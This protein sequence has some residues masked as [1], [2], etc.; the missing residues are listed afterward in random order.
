MKAKL[1]IEEKVTFHRNVEAEFPDEMSEE[2]IENLLQDADTE[3]GYSV[4][5]YIYYLK[6]HGAK[7]EVYDDSPFDD[8]FCVDVCCDDFSIG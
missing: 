2:D 4:D 3:E 6:R 8:P 5:G 1:V 7:I